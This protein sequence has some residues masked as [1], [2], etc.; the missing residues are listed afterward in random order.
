MKLKT[1]N[2]FLGLFGK[3]FY[4]PQAVQFMLPFSPCMQVR[5]HFHGDS[6]LHFC[7]Q[8]HVHGNSVLGGNKKS[9]GRNEQPSLCC[10]QAT[11]QHF[12]KRDHLEM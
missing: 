6:N 12:V 8:F 9:R 10:Y 2:S 3:E 4:T 5:G 7:K 11:G 1:K